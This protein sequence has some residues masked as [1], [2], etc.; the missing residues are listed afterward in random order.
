MVPLSFPFGPDSSSSQKAADTTNSLN[1]HLSTITTRLRQSKMT[2]IFS[3]S[4]HSDITV[5][6]PA[7]RKKSRKKKANGVLNLIKGSISRTD[8]SANPSSLF[9]TCFFFFPY[10]MS[11]SSLLIIC[12]H[13]QTHI[14]HFPGCKP[15]DAKLGT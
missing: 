14:R 1:S 13:T 9:Q 4:P 15:P 5:H 6:C 10:P 12:T 7:E 8:C 3:P 2:M 11:Q